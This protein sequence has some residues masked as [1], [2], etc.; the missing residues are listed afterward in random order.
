MKK[1]ISVLLALIL[2]TSLSVMVSSRA[3]NPSGN[4]PYE[5]TIRQADP[6]DVI[7]DGV[8]GEN[9]YTKLDVSNDPETTG[10][11][12][13]FGDSAVYNQAEAMVSTMAFYLSWDKDHGLNIAVTGKSGTDYTQNY[14]EGENGGEYRGDQFLA[15]GGLQIEL[16]PFRTRDARKVHGVLYYCIGKNPATGEYLEGSYAELGLKGNYDPAAGTDYCIS[17]RD[18]GTAVFEW[19][20]PFDQF[21]DYEVKNDSEIYLSVC[22]TG[23]VG[24]DGTF[25][26]CYGVGLGDFVFLGDHLTGSPTNAVC[27]ISDEMIAE[28]DETTAQTIPLDPEPKPKDTTISGDGKVIIKETTTNDK[29][30]VV[31]VERE[32]TED[33]IAEIERSE[34]V[35]AAQTADPMV[36][37]IAVCV[38]SAAAL[39]VLALRKRKS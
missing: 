8:I 9:E 20:V 21:A 37:I 34:N 16:D 10:L 18:D 3:Y 30:E 4:C 33:E 39:S 6:S 13:V 36:I 5:F 17:Y 32:A 7:K 14:T 29:G 19:S 24:K 28:N 1:I 26:G 23:G 2:M 38:I 31:V 22:M 35:P 27:V 15:N 12:L 11:V 25:N